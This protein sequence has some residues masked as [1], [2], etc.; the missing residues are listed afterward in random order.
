VSALAATELRWATPA[1]WAGGLLEHARELLSDHAHCE[2][3]AAIAAQSLLAK[4]PDRRRAVERLSATAIE[5]MRHFRRVH[6]LLGELGGTLG[7]ALPNA[8]AEGLRR[9]AARTARGL[10][11]ASR[12]L[13]RLLVAHL[14]ELRSA[15]RFGL[16]AAAPWSDAGVPD[17]VPELFADLL[18]SE[19][20]HARLFVELA[21]EGFGE[22]R[23]LARLDVLATEEAEVLRALPFGPRVHSGPPAGPPGGAPGGESRSS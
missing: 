23:A 4:N 14:I 12:Y 20:G 10:E 1:G 13:D 19:R 8:Y 17:A 22:E 3:Q 2:L 5:E 6:A 11:G 18:E 15:E 9:A 7:P 21:A 16:L